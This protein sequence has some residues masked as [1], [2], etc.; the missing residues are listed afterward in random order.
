MRSAR[1]VIL[2][3]FAI[4]A[5]TGLTIGGSARLS[6]ADSFGTGGLA[7]G[8]EPVYGYAVDHGISTDMAGSTGAGPGGSIDRGYTTWYTKGTEPIYQYAVN[9][10]ATDMD[11]AGA[12]GSGA[13]GSVGSGNTTGTEPVYRYLIDRGTDSTLP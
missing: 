3:A 6:S 12:T 10:G 9:R 5:L 1:R 4:A 8:T 13:G 11:T 7:T 2:R